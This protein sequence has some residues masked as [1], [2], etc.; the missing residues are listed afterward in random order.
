MGLLT[1]FRLPECHHSSSGGPRLP[2]PLGFNLKDTQASHTY[3]TGPEA[4]SHDGVSQKL[5]ST[6]LPGQGAWLVRRW[7][8]MH[9]RPSDLSSLPL[10]GPKPED[11]VE[12]N[13]L[14]LYVYASA[15]VL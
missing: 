4:G 1:L 14:R 2:E 9:P 12:T 8:G 6:Q 7:W 15:V 13:L 10:P 11:L 3:P 5:V